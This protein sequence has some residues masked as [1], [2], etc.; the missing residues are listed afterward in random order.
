MVLTAAYW[1]LNALGMSLLARGFG[2]DLGAP[3][4]CALL[5]VLVVGVMIP[6]GPG[7]L[8]TFQG[9]ILVGL[10]MFAPR[11]VVATRGAAYANVLWAVQLSVQAALGLAFLFSRHIRIAHIFEAPAEVGSGLDAEEE[12]Y[13]RTEPRR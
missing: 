1:A 13:Q 8:G 4:S 10:S 6:A 7:M 3:E 2:F 9:A 11:E 12:E 5:G